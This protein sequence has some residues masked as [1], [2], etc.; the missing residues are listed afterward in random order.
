MS[1]LVALL[2]T[3]VEVAKQ[4]KDFAASQWRREG[5]KIVKEVHNAK[6]DEERDAAAK[7]IVD[8]INDSE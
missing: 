2:N 1:I 4:W 6:T 3:V 5:K 7:R 8:H